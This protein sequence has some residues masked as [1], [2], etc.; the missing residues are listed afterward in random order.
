MYSPRKDALQFALILLTLTVFSATASSIS[1]QENP[2]KE[3]KPESSGTEVSVPLPTPPAVTGK[4]QEGPVIVN[5]D[6]I[7]LTVTVTDTY[8]R[9]V[10]G[11]NK[12]A[13]TVL[14][15]KQPQDI[16]FFSDDDS[17]VSV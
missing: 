16:T 6:L 8:G 4:D 2:A 10:S 12:N 11:L 3:T 15:D 13:F 17:P 7:T 9:Y 5:T 1:A 14:D